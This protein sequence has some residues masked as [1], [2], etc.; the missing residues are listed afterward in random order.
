MITN[1]VSDY[2]SLLVGIALIICNHPIYMYFFE[3]SGSMNNVLRPN[4]LQ[5]TVY[6]E[7]IWY[8]SCLT[9]II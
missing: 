6:I 7:S 2:V 9:T 4:L 8:S 5:K 1:D 3:V